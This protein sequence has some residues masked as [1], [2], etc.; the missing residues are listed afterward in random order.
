MRKI[1]KAELSMV[2]P[3]QQN[4]VD[5]ALDRLVDEGILS[6]ADTPSV[7][8]DELYVCNYGDENVSLFCN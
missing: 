2:L 4:Q 5:I 6:I 3:F 8:G 1:G 7:W